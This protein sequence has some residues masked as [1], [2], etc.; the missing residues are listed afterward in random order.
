MGII[1][2][3]RVLLFL[4]NNILLT[5]TLVDI[6]EIVFKKSFVCVSFETTMVSVAEINECI[7]SPCMNGASCADAVKSYTCGC[8]DGYTGTHCE[9]GS[10][11]TMTTNS[12]LRSSMLNLKQAHSPHDPTISL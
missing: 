9:T 10:S 2:V 11:L 8:V 1:S 3:P 4:Q 7:S 5:A 6:D 12:S